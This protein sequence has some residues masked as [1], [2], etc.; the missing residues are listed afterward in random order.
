MTD[1]TVYKDGVVLKLFQ[2]K[3][4][5]GDLSSK[6][7]TITNLN[8]EQKQVLTD[9]V[10]K[11]IKRI[12]EAANEDLLSEKGHDDNDIDKEKFQAWLLEAFEL[13]IAE[14]SKEALASKFLEPQ[15]PALLLTKYVELKE[16]IPQNPKDTNNAGGNDN[17]TSDGRGTNG[18]F[19]AHEALDNDSYRFDTENSTI[20]LEWRKEYSIVKK[21]DQLKTIILF[22]K[23]SITDDKSGEG[24]QRDVR[25]YGVER[26]YPD[27]GKYCREIVKKR[28]IGSAALDKWN[29]I[30]ENQKLIINASQRVRKHTHGEVKYYHFTCYMVPEMQ[31][32]DS[33]RS[34]PTYCCVT[35]TKVKGFQILTYSQLQSLIGEERSLEYTH[36]TCERDGI[37]LPELVEARDIKTKNTRC[38]R[39]RRDRKD[40]K[41]NAI[42][43][44]KQSDPGLEE[45]VNKLIDASMEVK[46]APVRKDVVALREQ[47]SGMKSEVRELQTSLETRFTSVHEGLAKLNTSFQQLVAT[48]ASNKTQNGVSPYGTPPPDS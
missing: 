48:L 41:R 19:P 26:F 8:E 4:A 14:G 43:I 2:H 27:T 22:E 15:R 23:R 3:T 38:H 30:P 17:T 9:A 12:K 20:E 18:L 24:K 39:P 32:W 10:T 13:E 35:T 47:F 33:T 36:K 1:L 37:P 25:Y 44:T 46:L 5:K 40:I 28:E 29:E 21:G 7:P 6:K 45:D 31:Y 34:V 42:P 16:Q 11:Q